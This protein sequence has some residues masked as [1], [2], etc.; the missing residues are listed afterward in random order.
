MIYLF[1][2][3]FGIHIPFVYF[4]STCDTKRDFSLLL[5]F[6]YALFLAVPHQPCTLLYN[7]TVDPVSI[8]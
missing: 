5:L 8:L 6:S 2:S 4:D 7:S 1:G 3:H